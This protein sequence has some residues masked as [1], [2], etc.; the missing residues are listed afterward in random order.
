MDSFSDCV[1]D[2]G[3]V[4]H[5]RL[6]QD[7]LEGYEMKFCGMDINIEDIE[8]ITFRRDGR[9]ITIAAKDAVSPRI[10]GFSRPEPKVNDVK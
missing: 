5:C 1:G 6:F 8:S 7:A 10:E 2:L 9:L 3:G 4:L